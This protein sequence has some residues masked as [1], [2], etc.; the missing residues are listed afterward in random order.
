MSLTNPNSSMLCMTLSESCSITVIN[1]CKP[2]SF[3][4]THLGETQEL[5]G[6]PPTQPRKSISTTQM[7]G[8]PAK[9]IYPLRYIGHISMLHG[10]VESSSSDT[11]ATCSR[12]W[13]VKKGR[14]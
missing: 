11:I 2:A 13:R 7:V 9:N 1:R 8:K 3:L 5:H 10:M 12:L 4:S 6:Q 14:L